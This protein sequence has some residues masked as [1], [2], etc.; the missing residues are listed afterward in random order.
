ML[1]EKFIPAHGSTVLLPIG[2]LT[3]D[4]T[5]VKKSTVDSQHSVPS[6]PPKWFGGLNS[7]RFI[8]AFIVVLFH[9]ENPLQLY[10]RESSV[11]LFQYAGMFMAVAFSGVAAVVAFFVISGFVIHYPNRKGIK[12]TKRFY[13]KRLVRVLGPLIVIMLLGLLFGN[14]E[15]DVVWSLYCELIYYAI[16]PIVAKIKMT[17]NVKLLIAFLLAS[18]VVV[19]VGQSDIR[20]MLTHSDQGY[21][22]ELWRFGPAFT[23]LVGLPCWLLGVTLAERIDGLNQRVS[24]NKIWLLRVTL[25]AATIVCC[26]LRFHMFVPYGISM[27]VMAI[28][29]AKWVEQ[30]IIYYKTKEPSA[31]LERFGKFSYSLYLCHPLIITALLLYVPLT[32]YSYFGYLAACIV[33]AYLFYLLLEKPSHMLAERLAGSVKKI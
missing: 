21:V 2:S 11:K 9:C 19:V 15:R 7:I 16:Y 6:V 30:E 23:W 33:G 28:P 25:Y 10:L 5:M 24:I 32:N 26:V 12:D 4:A 17:W 8:L 31:M 14:P 29:I 18:V 13:I 1:Y 22:G 20:S 27:L 3:T